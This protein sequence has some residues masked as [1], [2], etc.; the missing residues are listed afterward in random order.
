MGKLYCYYKKIHGSVEKELYAYTENKKYDARFRK[1][2]KMDVFKRAVYDVS[3]H[4]P[5]L[6]IFRNKN[7]FAQLIE[8]PLTDREGNDISLIG[9]TNEETYLNDAHDEL[10][11]LMDYTISTL[12]AWGK[13]GYIKKDFIESTSDIVDY[14]WI[15]KEKSTTAIDTFHLFRVLNYKTFMDP[16]VWPAMERFSDG[17]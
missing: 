3:E 12:A 4:D 1:E 9:T 5:H 7:K 8:I 13:D 10:C 11:S 15:I 17:L 14:E 6:W 16:D 2:R